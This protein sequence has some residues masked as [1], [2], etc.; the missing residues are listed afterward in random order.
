VIDF[1]EVPL[2]TAFSLNI[3]GVWFG[4]Y[5]GPLTTGRAFVADS[6]PT[7]SYLEGPSMYVDSGS[8]LYPVGD[9]RIRIYFSTLRTRLAFGLSVL[10]GADGHR[11][12]LSLGWGPGSQIGVG[13]GFVGVGST[14]PFDAVEFYFTNVYALAIDNVR[15]DVPVPEPASLLLFG[16]GLVGLRAWRK[17]QQ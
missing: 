8:P 2:G 12:E 13:D 10:P 15:Y 4:G 3:N 6:F 11:G 17:R 14:V 1:T 9:T 5:E 16:T 7:T